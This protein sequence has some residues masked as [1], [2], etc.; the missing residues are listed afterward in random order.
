MGNFNRLNELAEYIEKNLENDIDMKKLSQI[1]CVN[2]YTM[3]RIFKFITD[4]SII[5]YIRNRRLSVAGIELLN[6]DVKIIDIA[7]KYG[8]DSPISFSRAFKTFHGINPSIVKREKSY[9]KTFPPLK[10]LDNLKNNIN[11][12]FKIVEKEELSLYGISKEYNLVEIK[13]K[14][15]L[16]WQDTLLRNKNNKLFEGISYGVI[17]YDKLFPTPK[18]AKYYIALDKYFKGSS[19]INITKSTWVVFDV[20]KLDG[21]YMSNLSLYVYENW[22][23]Y[24]GYNIKNIPEIEV[25]YED[26]IEWWLPVEKNTK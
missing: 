18:K 19:K 9:L 25:Y 11:L 20:E 15:P 6:S 1:L 5:E 26:H 3:Y 16:F 23:P 12:K 10:F 17:K 7:I 2:E 8:Y 21:N 22:I 24:S 4:I 13:T 14:A